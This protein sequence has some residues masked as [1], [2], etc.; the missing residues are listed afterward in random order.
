MWLP[1]QVHLDIDDFG[2][3]WFGEIVKSEKTERDQMKVW[4]EFT[5]LVAYVCSEGQASA[6]N[7]YLLDIFERQNIYTLWPTFKE[8]WSNGVL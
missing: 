6:N 4:N 3:W 2:R 1:E 5:I 7:A 8:H